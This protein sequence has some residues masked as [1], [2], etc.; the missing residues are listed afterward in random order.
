VVPNENPEVAEEDYAAA[1]MAV[2]NIALAAVE[3]GL[4]T[5][6]KSGAV[7]QDPAA[8]AAVGVA[9]DQRIVAVVHVGEPAEAPPAKPRAPSSELTVW[10]P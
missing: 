10:V 1:M 8:R 6:I 5:H 9:D 2:Q 4:G 7:L 3:F